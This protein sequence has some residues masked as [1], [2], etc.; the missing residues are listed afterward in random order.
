MAM[1]LHARTWLLGATFAASLL[2]C[3]GGGGEAD[4]N[5]GGGNGGAGGGA[6]LDCSAYKDG[7]PL[8]ALTITVKNNRAAPVYIMGGECSS[9]F[10]VSAPD[11]MNTVADRTIVDLTCEQSQKISS[12]PLDCLTPGQLEIA[13]GG[14]AKLAWNGLLYQQVKMPDG[15]YLPGA[16]PRPTQCLQGVAPKMGAL[17][18]SVRVY[19][20]AQCQ[21]E[22][23]GCALQ[24]PIDLS[25]SFNY[26]SDSAI[27]ID[28]D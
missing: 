5:G 16:V 14:T 23:I 2:A 11:L 6:A 1:K 3:G 20:S 15:C 28:V 21:P 17:E 27:Q 25:K 10:S 22:P 18:A 24:D 4:D 26:P 8:G 19:R 9:S 12:F 7:T 13:P